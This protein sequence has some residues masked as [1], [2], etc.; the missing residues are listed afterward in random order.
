MSEISQPMWLNPDR[1]I[2]LYNAAC[3]YC[4]K[5]F[6]PGLKKTCDHVVARDF[7]PRGSLGW[8]VILNACR[9]CNGLKS[10]LE[11]DL[12]AITMQPDLMGRYPDDDPVLRAAAERKAAGAIS[13]LTKKPVQK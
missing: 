5:T 13:E 2:R 4:D 12:S 11:N 1:P 3:P 9:A 6:G 10:A 7:V 8:N